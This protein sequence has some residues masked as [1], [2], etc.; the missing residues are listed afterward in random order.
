[1]SVFFPIQTLVN[2]KL[3]LGSTY[4]DIM[5]HPLI[6]FSAHSVCYILNF[7]HLSV[8]IISVTGLFHLT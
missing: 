1:M 6:P 3:V 8:W 2:R 7:F 4:T 5:L